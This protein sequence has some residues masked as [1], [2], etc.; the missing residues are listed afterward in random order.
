MRESSIRICLIN[1]PELMSV[2]GR[3]QKYIPPTAPPLGLLY[4][5]ATL[6]KEG[7]PVSVIDSYAE[8]YDVAMTVREALKFKPHL[9]GINAV[10]P[11]FG[12]AIMIAR[13]IK[14]ANPDITIVMGG[15]HITPTGQ[16]V[17]EKYECVDICVK[18]E[19]EYTFLELAQKKPLDS[20]LGI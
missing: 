20:I 6:E 17:L 1:T 4:I 10:T 12:N 19:G 5:A 7:F 11:T 8:H 15:P 13:A 2:Y 14:E 16:L 18:H 9:V 3:I